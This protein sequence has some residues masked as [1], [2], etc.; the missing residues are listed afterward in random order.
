MYTRS[1]YS[2]VRRPAMPLR[3]G[4]G[5][6]PGPQAW[7][8]LDAAQ[9]LHLLLLRRKVHA[10]ARGPAESSGRAAPAACAH[11]RAAP[12]GCASSTG[13]MVSTGTPSPSP[14]SSLV[15]RQVVPGEKHPCGLRGR[16]GSARSRSP[17][18]ARG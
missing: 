5:P 12:R 14:F 4:R 16:G 7:L 6:S 11:S 8:S 2:S 15:Q 17:A 1:L 10:A 18:S 13:C 9:R 3:G